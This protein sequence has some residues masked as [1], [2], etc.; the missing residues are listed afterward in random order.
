MSFLRNLDP[1]S[2][3]PVPET[4]QG[5]PSILCDNHSPGVISPGISFH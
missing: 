4:G 1:V 3:H 5:V 2:T